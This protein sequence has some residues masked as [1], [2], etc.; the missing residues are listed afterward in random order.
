MMQQSC[1]HPR[2]V[3]SVQATHKCAGCKC[4]IRI[5]TNAEVQ[6]TLYRAGLQG[7][8]TKPQ[9]PCLTEVT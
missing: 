2:Q 4:N 9:L 1:S 6:V 8:R 5:T 3:P 7:K